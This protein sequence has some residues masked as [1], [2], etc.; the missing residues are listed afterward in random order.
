[1]KN[2]VLTDLIMD[3]SDKPFVNEE[4]TAL[5]V[6]KE[7][8]SSYCGSRST[9]HMRLKCLE[10]HILVITVCNY[11]SDASCR[12]SDTAALQECCVFFL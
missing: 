3:P 8:R 4:P 7:E 10:F 12:N 11:E 6:L 5:A 9:V 1:M 2:N